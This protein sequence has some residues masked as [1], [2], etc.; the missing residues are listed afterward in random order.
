MEY[1]D[2]LFELGTEELPPKTLQLLSQAL[3]ESVTQQLTAAGLTFSAPK[4]FATP[5]RLGLFLSALSV[6]QADKIIEKKGPA[7]Q[8]A[9]KAGKPTPAMLG[10]AKSCGVAADALETIQTDKG[11]RLVYRSTV[12]GKHVRTLMPEIINTAINALPIAKRMRW[13]MSKETFV[14]P[15]HWVVMLL[16]DEIINTTLFGLNSERK[17]WGHRVHAPQALIIKTPAHYENLLKT[18]GKVMTSFEMRRAQIKTSAEQL[19]RQAGGTVVIHDELLDEITALTEWPVALT[20]TFDRDFLKLPREVIAAVME[21]H[22]KYFFVND[23]QG[24]LL[25]VFICIAN[26]ESQDTAQ[27]IAG[28]ERVIRPRLADA[29]FFYETDL[30]KSLISQ[31]ERLKTV[32]FQKALGTLFDKTTRIAQLA[33]Q[34]GPA[35][36]SE[37]CTDSE[38]T[39]QLH[40]IEQAALL[41]KSDLVCDMVAEF[42]ELQGITGRY[43]A[44]QEGLPQ[45]VSLALQEQYLPR[46]SGDALPTTTAGKALALAEKIDTLVGMFGINKAPSG[47]KD[48]FSLRRLALGAV[49]IIIEQVTVSAMHLLQLDQLISQSIAQFQQQGVQFTLTES[50]LKKQLTDFMLERLKNWSYSEQGIST[51][52]THYTHTHTHSAHTLHTHT[53]TH[54][55]T[56]TRSLTHAQACN[57]ICTNCKPVEPVFS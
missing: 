43:Y 18:A 49:R 30:K 45:Q 52:V 21:K 48:P 22:Q 38:K 14:R 25:P 5:R 29:Q 11:E 50:D 42:P 10:F 56:Y 2:F 34:T 4:T 39:Q 55:H 26:L 31:R 54:T 15:V 35:F 8:A 12:P 32:V 37:T 51:A 16:G 23:A 17:T 9:F 53:H 13:G 40:N 1:Q 3:T 44:Q 27:I 36:I 41:C 24:N 33:K 7:V 47:N 46:F 28:N 19:A 20:G 57:L 6:K